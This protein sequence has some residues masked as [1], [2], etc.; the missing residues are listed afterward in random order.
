MKV[1][2]FF[3]PADPPG[4]RLKKASVF[5]A[6]EISRL[7]VLIQGTDKPVLRPYPSDGR[8]LRSWE[9]TLGRFEPGQE[10]S[11]ALVVALGGHPAAALR[12]RYV[13]LLRRILLPQRPDPQDGKEWFFTRKTFEAWAILD[14]EAKP[15]VAAP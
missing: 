6:S 7:T 11:D 14:P 3:F 15:A 1:D 12:V 10:V 5:G 2:A 4:T 13:G 8:E 9:K